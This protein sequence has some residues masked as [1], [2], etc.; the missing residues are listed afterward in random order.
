MK[1]PYTPIRHALARLRADI[2]VMLQD[3]LLLE[4]GFQDA[5]V[6]PLLEASAPPSP[7]PAPHRVPPAF[8]PGL[9]EDADHPL[10]QPSPEF[11]GPVSSPH[12]AIGV[13]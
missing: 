3:T 8:V 1:N 9:P 2:E 11:P 4:A 7:P 5:Q 10:N 6:R 13:P 12:R